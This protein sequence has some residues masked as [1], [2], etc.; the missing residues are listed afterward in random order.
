MVRSMAS[1][2]CRAVPVTELV[3]Q[4]TARKPAC[5]GSVAQYYTTD[6]IAIVTRQLSNITCGWWVLK[7][8]SS[9][10]GATI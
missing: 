8:A 5:R 4:P 6:A 9:A 2:I 7:L 3:L 1:C 10:E